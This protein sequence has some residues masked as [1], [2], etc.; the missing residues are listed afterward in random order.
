MKNNG[1]NKTIRKFTKNQ[2]EL[3]ASISNDIAEDIDNH[4][5]R[6]QLRVAVAYWA[7]VAAMLQQ[8]RAALE[9]S[10]LVFQYA[11]GLMDSALETTKPKI[12]AGKAL[13]PSGEL[14]AFQ[15]K[16]KLKNLPG[17]A[18]VAI[19]VLGHYAAPRHVTW[20]LKDNGIIISG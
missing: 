13:A 2:M 6:E 5:T 4:E 15:L 20:C 10:L 8:R 12:P 1:H 11:K 9:S 3:A 7:D 14:N 16:D 17:D 19:S 18:S